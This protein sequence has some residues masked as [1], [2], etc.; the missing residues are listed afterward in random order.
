VVEGADGLAGGLYPQVVCQV[1]GLNCVIES[2]GAI[3]GS[4]GGVSQGARINSG[5]RSI[6]VDISG[7]GGLL[8]VFTASMSLFAASVSAASLSLGGSV[9]AHTAVGPALLLL[10]LGKFGVSRLALH[11]AKLISLR[12]LTTATSSTFLLK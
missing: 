3:V 5:L 10:L 12:A 6:I 1:E 7:K 11:S 2:R 9:S 4:T 8:G